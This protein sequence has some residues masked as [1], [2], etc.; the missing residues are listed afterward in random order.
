LLLGPVAVTAGGQLSGVP[1]LSLRVLLATL[2]TANSV[3]PTAT[4][5]DSLWQ[6]EHSQRRVRNLHTRVYELRRWLAGMMTEARAPKIVTQAPGYRL[7]VA[8]SELDVTVFGQLAGQA[9]D[10]L[11][12]GDYSGSAARYRQALDLWRGPALADVAQAAPRLRDLAEQLEEQRLTVLS[13]RI[14]ADLADGL[15]AELLGELTGLVQRYPFREHLRYQLMLSL[16]R[17]GRQAD[18]LVAYQDARRTLREE[19]GI[20]PGPELTDLH[21]RILMADA[22]LAGPHPAGRT[23]RATGSPPA[24]GVVPRQLPPAITR[25]AGRAVELDALD[26]MLR[27]AEA[28]RN[29]LIV[30]VTGGPGVGKS[31]LAVRWAHE[32]SGRFPDG[33][34]YVNLHGFGPAATPT[35]PEQAVRAIL[36]ALDVPAAR[37]PATLE[38]QVGLY[39]S[40]VAGRRILL[41]LDNASQADQVRPLLP[42]G[43]GC[44]V[45][46][47]SRNE[48]LGLAVTDDARLLPLAVFSAAEAGELLKLRRP[49]EDDYDAAGE[50][51]EL[52]ARLP[53]ALAIVLAR[54]DARPGRPLASLVEELRADSTRLDVLDT[55]DEKV[56]IRTAFC[57]SYRNLSE[58]PA[59][60]FRLL[61]S[62]PRPETGL[63]EA[64]SLT[65][66][67]V[68]AARAVL[69]EL[70]AVGLI[71]ENSAGRFG[72]HDLLRLFASE[73][74]AGNAVPGLL[75]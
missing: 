29:A 42:G 5:I 38:A 60:M 43:A 55:G 16:Y 64:A 50:L 59:L 27:E 36:D 26:R 69:G 6:E 61:A 22:G 51:I 31:A 14:G 67:P 74:M 17:C 45:V 30:V 4:L 34:V 66:F 8:D 44:V 39:R 62:H 53:L 9:R 68:A 47:T 48:Q 41:V 70:T 46:V 10:A 72:F 28:S 35:H 25:F 11:R 37:V 12:A 57:W 52:C 15:D 75:D 21:Q 3:V 1:Q 24:P 58:S 49:A 71:T 33:Q 56:S 2:A 13:E 23:A 65:G 54:A 18:A 32:I 40:L 63:L 20:D 7:I 73:L 19:F